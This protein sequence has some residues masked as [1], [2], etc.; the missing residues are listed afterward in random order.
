MEE[1]IEFRRTRSTKGQWVCHSGTYFKIE[2]QR[3]TFVIFEK[4]AAL[5]GVK[6]KDCV[7]F[8]FN[9]KEQYGYIYKEEPEEDSY[10]LGNSGRAYYRFTSKELMA[11]FDEIF[12][13]PNNNAVYFKVS[14]TPNE[15][16][17][18]KFTLKK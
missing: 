14:E 13:L 16:G 1:L 6:D 10:Y 2:V 8:S 9:K 11:F 4:L 12:D 18:Y 17:W 5:L 15:K 7:M 3:G